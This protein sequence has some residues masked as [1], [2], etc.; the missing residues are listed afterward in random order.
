MGKS[1]ILLLKQGISALKLNLISAVKCILVLIYLKERIYT[2]IYMKL[3]VFLSMPLYIYE[4]E[5]SR[6]AAKCM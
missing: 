3:Q 2:A 4:N 1:I 5:Q 6:K